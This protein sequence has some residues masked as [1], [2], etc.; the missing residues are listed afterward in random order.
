M[1]QQGRPISEEAHE[2]PYWGDR[3]FLSVWESSGFKNYVRSA[4]KILQT[5][6]KSLVQG[7]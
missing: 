2:D 4:S 3:V 6:Q 7:L 5:G 1:S